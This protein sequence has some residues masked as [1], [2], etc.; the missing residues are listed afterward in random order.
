VAR[1]FLVRWGDS[2][3]AQ[4]PIT[5]PPTPGDLLTGPKDLVAIPRMP[6]AGS[7]RV[8]ILNTSTQAPPDPAFPTWLLRLRAYLGVGSTAR[9]VVWDLGIFGSE[10]PV[11]AFQTTFGASEVRITGELYLAPS[12]SPPSVLPALI[13]AWITCA[14]YSP[15]S[16]TEA[17]P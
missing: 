11:D 8:W 12:S 14:P 2:I 15:Y 10:Y 16:A 5:P 1:G 13:Q 9:Q 4:V 17:L 6:G 7:P 3:Q